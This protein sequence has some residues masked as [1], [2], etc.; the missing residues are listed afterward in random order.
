MIILK[1]FLASM[2]PYEDM[3]Y[4]NSI[5]FIRAQF[6]AIAN[7]TVPSRDYARTRDQLDQLRTQLDGISTR[8]ARQSLLV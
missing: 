7:S 8:I 3:A 4:G 2:Q 1:E 5:K 6:Q